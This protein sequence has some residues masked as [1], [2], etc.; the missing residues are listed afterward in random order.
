MNEGAC[1]QQMW[2]IKTSESGV[3]S[4]RQVLKDSSEVTWKILCVSGF[5]FLC[6]CIVLWKQQ[7][8]VKTMKGI[9]WIVI[10]LESV[11]TLALSCPLD[12]KLSHVRRNDQ[13]LPAKSS[14]RVSTPAS[15]K[16]A[17]GSLALPLCLLTPIVVQRQCG[18][19]RRNWLPKEQLKARMFL[20]KADTALA[21]WHVRQ[22]QEDL[23][24]CGCP[25]F[26]GTQ[27][28]VLTFQE[29]TRSPGDCSIETAA[30]DQAPQWSA[31]PLLSDQF[32]TP[33]LISTGFLT[34]KQQG[35]KKW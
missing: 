13:Q 11:P 15:Y 16:S 22:S 32:L 27:V 5:H 31:L 24:F 30:A 25:G 28:V 29:V 6:L 1:S 10:T 9:C 3:H 17:V 12:P 20:L 7:A 8:A 23:T 21:S 2:E 34:D 26:W 18:A 4:F 14:L 35:Q 33:W 19:P